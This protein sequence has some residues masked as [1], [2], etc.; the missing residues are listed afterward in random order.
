[1]KLKK[2]DMIIYDQKNEKMEF[3]QMKNGFIRIRPIGENY[4][5]D[6]DLSALDIIPFI[7]DLRAERARDWKTT[8][9]ELKA[10]RLVKK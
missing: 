9:P 1:M 6:S 4:K 3:Y 5:I 2:G 8:D 10:F 7:S